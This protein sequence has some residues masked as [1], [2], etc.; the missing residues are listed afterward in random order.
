MFF[1]LLLSPTAVAVVYS[2]GTSYLVWVLPGPLLLLLLASSFL[3]PC[4]LF[5]TITPRRGPFFTFVGT[6]GNLVTTF[7][8]Y[9]LLP[10]GIGTCLGF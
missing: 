6:L 5:S 7:D 3:H 10:I 1:I 2:V 4:R 8:V 9:P